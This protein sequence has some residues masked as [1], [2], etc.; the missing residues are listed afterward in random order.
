MLSASDSMRSGQNGTLL[1]QNLAQSPTWSIVR[2]FNEFLD[3]YDRFTQATS[4]SEGLLPVSR[5]NGQDEEL[6]EA[7][8]QTQHEKAKQRI[9]TL[10]YGNTKTS[11]VETE[12]Q[13]ARPKAD[14]IWSALGADDERLGSVDEQNGCTWDLITRSASR[15]VRRLLKGFPQG[16][17]I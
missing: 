16:S 17:T 14:E 9:R 8:L 4:A 15:G 12:A 6:L 1:V 7:V 11:L 3:D 10:M 5:P 13:I 2:S